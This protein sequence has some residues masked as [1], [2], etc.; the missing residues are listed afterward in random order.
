MPII[1]LRN[2]IIPVIL[3]NTNEAQSIGD[4]NFNTTD[5]IYVDSQDE[6]K[7]ISEIE[8]ITSPTD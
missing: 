2:C 4:Q 3:Q 5:L 7:D 6:I 1:D 8:R